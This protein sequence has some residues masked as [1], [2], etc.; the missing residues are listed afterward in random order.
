VRYE[1]LQPISR[2]E[3]ERLLS[4]DDAGDVCRALVSLALYEEDWSWVETLCVQMAHDPRSQV[5]G[6]AVTG[7]GHLARIHGVLH[8]QM[9]VPLLEAL[10][11]D[12]KIGGRAEDAL[13]DIRMFAVRQGD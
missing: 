2:T 5:R 11:A 12:P 1:Q 6:C 3:A 9:V 4:S 8:L 7:I 10:A 13:S